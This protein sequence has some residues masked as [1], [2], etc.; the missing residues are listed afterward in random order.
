MEE[1]CASPSPDKPFVVTIEGN[2]GSGKSTFL[3]FFEDTENVTI[4]PEPLNLWTD[5]NGHNLLAMRYEDPEKNAFLFQ[6]YVLLTKI[7]ILRKPTKSQVKILERSV[8]SNKFC[9]L[10]LAQANGSLGINKLISANYRK[11]M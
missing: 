6:S 11:A 8:Q 5:L 4:C 3:K 7:Q 1:S 10:K 9:F 2:M